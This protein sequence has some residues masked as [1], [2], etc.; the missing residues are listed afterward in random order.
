MKNRSALPAKIWSLAPAFDFAHANLVN[1]KEVN[2]W[3][4]YWLHRIC[5]PKQNKRRGGHAVKSPRSRT[6]RRGLLTGIAAS[7][8]LA[9]LVPGAASAQAQPFLRDDMKK[10]PAIVAATGP[11][12]EQ[13]FRDGRPT[14]IS[15]RRRAQRPKGNSGVGAGAVGAGA[16]R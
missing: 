8:G 7:A 16:L 9:S 11:R 13:P 4:G 1:V 3:R 12:A 5:G 14:M 2:S 15:L 10:W 6:T